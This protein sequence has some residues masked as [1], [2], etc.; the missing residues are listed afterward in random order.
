M[1]A[2]LMTDLV[3]TPPIGYTRAE[4][5]AKRLITSKRSGW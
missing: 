1:T 4:W 5:D 2:D 3:T